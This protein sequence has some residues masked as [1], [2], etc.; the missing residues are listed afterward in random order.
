M[1][2]QPKT[3]RDLGRLRNRLLDAGSVW[4]SLA[5][6]ESAGGWLDSGLTLEEWASAVCGATCIPVRTG[7]W[8]AHLPHEI[9]AN[10]MMCPDS[11]S[12]GD[13][14]ACPF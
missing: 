8:C 10:A 9:A 13:C 12:D 4:E 1:S 11:D 2:K 3:T 6:G 14:N 5:L 7:S